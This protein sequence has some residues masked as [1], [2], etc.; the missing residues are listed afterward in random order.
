MPEYNIEHICFLT[1][2]QKDEL[3]EAITRIHSTTFGTPKMFVNV[4]I[5]DTSE[6]NLYVGGKRRRTNRIFAYVR[7]G[8]SRTQKDYESVSNQI[9]AEWDKIVPLPQVQ[10]SLPKPDQSLNLIMFFGCL[11]AGYEAGFMIPQAG[12]DQEWFKDNL[13][14][15]Q[16]KA[17]AGD[18]NF[19]EMIEECKER[20]F[21]LV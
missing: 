11:V 5:T 8:P 17:D 16:A 10:R 18:E 4:K 12:E 13:A 1:E 9:V 6:G 2:G 7:P 19:K 21:K 15:F 3:A 20:G 14:A